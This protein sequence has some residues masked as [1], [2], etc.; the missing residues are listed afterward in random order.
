MSS[1]LLDVPY[2]HSASIWS[3][4]DN[5]LTA[6]RE[7]ALT[8]GYAPMTSL[9]EKAMVSYVSHLSTHACCLCQRRLFTC[10]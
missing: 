10:S 7:A 4:V 8:T 3:F 6:V 2:K 5:T 9:A 1:Q